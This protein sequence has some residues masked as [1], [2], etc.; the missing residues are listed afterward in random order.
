MCELVSLEGAVFLL[1]ILLTLY[2]CGM[3][4]IIVVWPDSDKSLERII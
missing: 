2:G 1:H 3:I 4:A